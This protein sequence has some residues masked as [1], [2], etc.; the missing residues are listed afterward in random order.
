MS[1]QS[2]YSIFP[3]RVGRYSPAAADWFLEQVSQ[4]AGF[5]RR[6]RA[7]DQEMLRLRRQKPR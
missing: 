2:S 5:L 3:A 7:A 1:G 4:D 6:A